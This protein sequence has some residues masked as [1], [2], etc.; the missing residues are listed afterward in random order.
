[1]RDCCASAARWHCGTGPHVAA[2]GPGRAGGNP[3][4]AGRDDGVVIDGRRVREYRQAAL[5]GLPAIVVVW[6]VGVGVVGGLLV[7]ARPLRP[8][9][10][11]TGL[12][13]G[14][15]DP[16]TRDRRGLVSR[17]CSPASPVSLPATAISDGHAGASVPHVWYGVAAAPSNGLNARSRARCQRGRST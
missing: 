8:G 11:R 1:M 14:L 6:V 13:V 2:A 16:P 12:A 9:R 3:R 15:A 7:A 5:F 4:P 10:V 17:C